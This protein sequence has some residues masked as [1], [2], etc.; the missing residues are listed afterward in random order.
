[1][2]KFWKG[3]VLLAVTASVSA[4][5]GNLRDIAEIILYP[6]DKRKPEK[7]TVKDVR[8]LK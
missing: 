7:K 8:R 5:S 2:K 6:Y 1:M 4:C 3:L